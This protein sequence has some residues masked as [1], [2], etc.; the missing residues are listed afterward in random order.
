MALSRRS[1]K[2]QLALQQPRRTPLEEAERL[3]RT[4]FVGNLP[5]AIKAKRVKQTFARYGAVESVRLRSVPVKLDV[6]MPRRAA[7]LSG[8]VASD[9]GTANAYVVFVDTAAAAAALAHNMAEL[10]GLHLRVDIAAKPRSQGGGGGGSQAPAAAGEPGAVLYDPARSVFVGNLPF[11]VQDE[12]VIQAFTCMGAPAAGVSPAKG[13]GGPLG[14][15]AGVTAVRVV[16][17]GKTNVGKGFAFVE[18]ATPA[19]A[20]MA[21]ALNGTEVRKRPVRVTRVAA[22]GKA[23]RAGPSALTTRFN[24]DARGGGAGAA[25]A[26]EAAAAPTAAWQGLRTKGR[27]GKG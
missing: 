22:P 19:A 17:D 21:L 23:A 1:T 14:A 4:V 8:N 18:F 16:R 2:E 13:S 11:D 24:K 3:R 12:E 6:K 20:R 10:D 25:R 15:P 7:I 27:G 26:R 5:A 9:R